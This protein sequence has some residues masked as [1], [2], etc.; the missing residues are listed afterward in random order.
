MSTR[1]ISWGKGGRCLKLTTSPSS[2]GECHGNREPKP[3]GTLW[4]TP[5][6]LRDSF[7]FTVVMFIICLSCKTPWSYLQWPNSQRIQSE[8]QWK[9]ITPI[10]LLYIKNRC[11]RSCS[12]CLTI[13]YHILFHAS[14]NDGDTFWEMRSSAISSLCESHRVYLSKTR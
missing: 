11:V 4:A 13:S 6:L 9:T 2:C 14:L 12:Y 1:N 10:I 5:G 3:P 7:T 8:C